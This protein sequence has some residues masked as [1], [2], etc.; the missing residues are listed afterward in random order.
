MLKNIAIAT[1]LSLQILALPVA[2]AQAQ[3]A[4]APTNTHKA[5]H[6]KVRACRAEAAA[7]QLGGE[8][9]RAFIAKCMKG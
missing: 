7:Q 8:A 2:H 5:N 1:A 9:L 3:T 4:S 6:E